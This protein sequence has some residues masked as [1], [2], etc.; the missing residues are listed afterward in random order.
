MK[1]TILILLSIFL[2]IIVCIYMNYKENLMAQ[3]QAQKFNSEFEFY[4]RESILGTD[5]TTLIN[6]AMDNNEKLGVQ[7]D[8]NDMYV[9]DDEKSIKIYVHMI[10]DE[11]TYPMETLKKTGLAEFTRYFGE[12]E[13]KCTD[14][15]YHEKTGKIAEMT[16][17][18]TKE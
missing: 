3:M 17:A 11:T 12:V 10:L 18:A 6:K 8:E 4:N 2:A 16:F 14:V 15:K 5:V 13:F 7:K 1:K 9:A